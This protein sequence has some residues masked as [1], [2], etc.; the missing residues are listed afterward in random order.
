MNV[1][2]GHALRYVLYLPNP[3]AL[4]GARRSA[5]SLDP[6]HVSPKN[7]RSHQVYQFTKPKYLRASQWQNA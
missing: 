2:T 7:A 4:A 3:S 1:D 6:T 5:A